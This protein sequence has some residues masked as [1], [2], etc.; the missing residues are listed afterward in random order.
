MNLALPQTPHDVLPSLQ[1]LERP[2]SQGA[3]WAAAQLK[4]AAG[5]VKVPDIERDLTRHLPEGQFFFPAITDEQLPS[6][7]HPLS[8]Y[9]FIMGVLPDTKILKVQSSRYVETVLRDGRTVA[10]V[11]DKELDRALRTPI[12][13]DDFALGE[14]VTV[15]A[16]DWS[17]LIGRVADMLRD[18][19][20]VILI[21]LRSTRQIVKLKRHDIQKL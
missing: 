16:G 20:F 18:G 3:G 17:G 11:T 9:V 13:D 19:R 4:E 1:V 15:L 6:P 2:V 10:R 5:L 8:A 14:H 21:E 12:S 7:L